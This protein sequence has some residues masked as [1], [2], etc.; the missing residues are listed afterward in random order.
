M[1]KYTGPIIFIALSIIF[2]VLLMPFTAEPEIYSIEDVEGAGQFKNPIALKQISQ[3]KTADLMPLMQEFIGSSGSIVLNVRLNNVEDVEENLAE[4]RR[5]S[6]QFD[7]LVINLD[8]S[9]S[10][11]DEFRKNNAE[12]L[13]NLEELVNDSAAFEELNHLEIQY[14][15]ENNPEKMYSIAYEGEALRQK[16]EQEFADYQNTSVAL[17][18][19][20]EAVNIYS[21]QS[22]FSVEEFAEYM[23]EVDQIQEKR[24]LSISDINIELQEELTLEIDPPGGI[25]GDTINATGLYSQTGNIPTGEPVT[26]YIDSIKYAVSSCN[27]TGEYSIPISITKMYAGTHLAYTRIEDVFSPVI[28]VSV[29]GTDGIL[30]LNYSVSGTTIS[31]SGR[32]TTEGRCVSGAPVTLYI[33][34]PDTEDNA[35]VYTD[36]FG[37]YLYETEVEPG[38]YTIQSVF[39]D[40][41]FPVSECRSNKLVVPITKSNL[42]LYIILFVVT[43]AGAGYLILRR[44]NK[45]E[46]PKNTVISPKETSIFDKTEEFLPSEPLPEISETKNEITPAE[47]VAIREYR[48]RYISQR[49]VLSSAEAAHI[50]GEGF[51]AAIQKYSGQEC[52]PSE[53]MREYTAKLDDMCRKKAVVFVTLYEAIVYGTDQ[54][55]GDELLSAWDEV[56]TCIGGE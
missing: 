35:T 28:P 39:S 55:D 18:K 17:A 52:S 45:S 15:D 43:A 1:K 13:R 7:N 21:E 3:E 20:G 24:L 33:K 25:Y 40:P 14:Q 50:L 38:E 8:M 19:S 56:I 49:A 4:Y 2:V 11:I 31:S 34:G 29:T 54:Q 5:A 48:S 51:T 37:E 10:E 32:L 53:T 22:D 16:L 46:K 36:N 42:Y 12:N 27:V 26:L 47:V 9:E 44:R 41:V 6:K 23:D 30:T